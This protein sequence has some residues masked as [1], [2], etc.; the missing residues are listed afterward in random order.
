MWK[1]Y[2]AEKGIRLDGF[3][4]VFEATYDDE[5]CFYGETHDFWEIV[6]V[7]EGNI[8][9]GTEE[10]IFHLSKG[11]M[12]FHKPME[13]HKFHIENGKPATL[14]IMSFSASGSVL[15]RFEN[16][17]LRLSLEQN[18]AVSYMIS[19]LR[20]EC[21]LENG[22]S[23]T[24]LN[25]LAEYPTKFQRFTCMV[26]LLLLSLLNESNHINAVSDVPEVIAYRKAVQLMEKR[27]EEWISVP[28]I[29]KECH[30]SASYLKKVFAKY[31]GIGI[32]QYFLKMKIRYASQML[33][34]GKSV[35]EIAASLS[36]S[37]PNYFSTV[38]KRETGMTPLCYKKCESFK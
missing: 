16:C 26:E 9:V 1:C 35:S 21:A 12:I 28:E 10:H 15:K 19:F 24:C 33:K 17:V 20:E 3:F 38:F 36:F 13:F 29:A 25:E 37:S 31:L 18:R 23:F 4:S 30:V 32:H 11:E 8:C 14:F 27:I 34:E 6:F 22:F 7:R 2:K 5:F